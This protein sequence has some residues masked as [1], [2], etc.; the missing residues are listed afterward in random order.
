M[1]LV[2]WSDSDGATLFFGEGMAGGDNG[3]GEGADGEGSDG[4]SGGGDSGGGDN[5]RDAGTTT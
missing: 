3:E 2:L 1:L 5:G 4:D